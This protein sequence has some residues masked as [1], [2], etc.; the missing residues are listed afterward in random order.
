MNAAVSSSRPIPMANGLY[1]SAVS[2][3]PRRSRWRKCW[4]DDEAVGQP[5]ARREAHAARDHRRALVAERDHVFAEDAGAGARAATV[6]PFALR[7]AHQLRD[8]RAAEQRG[9][10][11]LVAAREEDTRGL[12]EALEPPR[13]WQSRRV[14]KSITSTRAAPMSLNSRS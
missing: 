11:Q 3:R 10:P 8:R 9:E 12:L 6:T 7:D 14:S 1:A 4:F 2:S 5:E 13:S